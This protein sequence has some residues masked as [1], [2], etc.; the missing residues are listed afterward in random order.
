M[1]SF[2]SSSYAANMPS[3]IRLLWRNPVDFYT[4]LVDMFLKI[5]PT[6]RNDLA[7][8]V[9]EA[10]VNM[11][12][13]DGRIQLLR[14]VDFPRLR[15]LLVFMNDDSGGELPLLGN[16]VVKTV[17]V[18]HRSSY[19]NKCLKILDVNVQCLVRFGQTQR[20][21]NTDV[22]DTRCYGDGPYGMIW[23]P[24]QSFGPRTWDTVLS[25][26]HW[27]GNDALKVPVMNFL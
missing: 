9:E 19:A 8:F 7:S 25:R 16:N 1:S 26:V 10:T 2:N 12:S 21:G 11:E 24:K 22:W 27:I 20:D 5:D 6:R 17:I 18:Q 14:D 15:K 4:N 3:A 13:R 23:V